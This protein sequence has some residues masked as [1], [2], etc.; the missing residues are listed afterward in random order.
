M[1]GKYDLILKVACKLRGREG[2]GSGTMQYDM[3]K[4]EDFGCKGMTV[5]LPAR[6]DILKASS[7]CLSID[8]TIVKTYRSYR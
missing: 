3:M 4:N 2:K 7:L 5:T 6:G 8:W 1:G